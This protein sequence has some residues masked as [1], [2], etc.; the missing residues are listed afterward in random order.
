MNGKYIKEF[1]FGESVE[2]A[3]VIIRHS[4][5]EYIELHF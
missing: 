1:L 4:I 3:I 2:T 5:S